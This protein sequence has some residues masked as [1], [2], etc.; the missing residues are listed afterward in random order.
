[1]LSAMGRVCVGVRGAV[2]LGREE[3]ITLP[4][5]SLELPGD[6]DEALD[7]RSPGAPFGALGLAGIWYRLI[8]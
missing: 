7:T 4:L 5:G 1:M 2:A 8:E 3:D 6:M